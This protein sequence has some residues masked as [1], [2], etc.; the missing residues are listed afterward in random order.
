M[1][2]VGIRELRQR[3][4]ELLRQVEQVRVSKS[5]IVDGP[6]RCSRLCRRV[7]PTGECWSRARSRGQAARRG[8][9]RHRSHAHQARSRHRRSWHVCAP[10]SVETLTYLNSSAIV[11]L[12]EV[13]AESMAHRQYLRRR[14]LYMSSALACRGDECGA[15]ARARSYPPRPRGLAAYRPGAHE[16]PRADLAG[17]HQPLR[18]DVG[19]PS[20]W[21]LPGY[22]ARL[23][24]YDGDG[25]RRSPDGCRCRF[26]SMRPISSGRQGYSKGTQ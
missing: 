8:S 25:D 17:E 5:A 23:V 13:A 7:V 24:N 20:T 19:M 2:S 26:A 12:V 6:L 15:A 11:R 9:Y 4:R 10:M 22:L 16:R 18:C 21:L 3:A 1:L 14:R